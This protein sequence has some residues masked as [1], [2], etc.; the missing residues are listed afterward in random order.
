MTLGFCARVYGIGCRGCIPAS[1]SA[2]RLGRRAFGPGRVVVSAHPGSRRQRALGASAGRRPG[3]AR[4]RHGNRRE[5]VGNHLEKNPLA[6]SRGREATNERER[7]DDGNGRESDRV[8]PLASRPG[9]MDDCE[10]GGSGMVTTTGRSSSLASSPERL[11]RRKAGIRTLRESSV[12]DRVERAVGAKGSHRRDR[13]G[14]GV[15]D[16]VG[17]LQ[18]VLAFEGAPSRQ[19]FVE[20]RGERELVRLCAK[21]SEGGYL[22]CAVREQDGACGMRRDKKVGRRGESEA[23]ELRPGRR[24]QDVFGRMLCGRTPRRGLV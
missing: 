5:L 2:R 13:G 16:R 23:R 18:N 9:T 10:D 6:D 14:L 1:S 3:R 7:D 21:G 11:A 8:L 24:E 4:R 20:T 12:E 19:R 15:S 17:D 22:G